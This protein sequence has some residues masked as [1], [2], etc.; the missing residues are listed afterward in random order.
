M[1]AFSDKP[2]AK[3]RP[4]GGI[5]VPKACA[6]IAGAACHHDVIDKNRHLDSVQGRPLLGFSSFPGAISGL[7]PQNQV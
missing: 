4:Q 1:R 6:D 5:W 2:L 7:L 3:C